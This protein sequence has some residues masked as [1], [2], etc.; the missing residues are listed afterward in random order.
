MWESA[1]IGWASMRLGLTMHVTIY[2]AFPYNRDQM[3]GQTSF[4]AYHIFWGRKVQI[5]QRLV[6]LVLYEVDT[7]WRERCPSQCIAR[8]K[9]FVASIPR[10][11]TVVRVTHYVS[12]C[13]GLHCK[14]SASG[15]IALCS[16][17]TRK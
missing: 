15:F 16:T 17:S 14:C 3:R 6:R 9:H 4:D 1:H 7:D 11:P 5:V 13:A 8:V 12:T 10:N 2:A